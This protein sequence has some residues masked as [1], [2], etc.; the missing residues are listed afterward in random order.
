MSP[1]YHTKTV[2]EDMKAT[3]TVWYYGTVWPPVM[4]QENLCA[5]ILAMRRACS[6]DCCMAGLVTCGWWALNDANLFTSSWAALALYCSTSGSKVF[7]H[8]HTSDKQHDSHFQLSNDFSLFNKFMFT[9][10]INSV[11]NTGL[12]M[13][14]IKG[15]ILTMN[16][17]L[18]QITP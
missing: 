15:H 17:L 2:L 3:T 18:S 1:V 13:D 10:N 5:N 9:I 6:D 7:I 4:Y 16:T 8:K 11:D 12:K 14:L